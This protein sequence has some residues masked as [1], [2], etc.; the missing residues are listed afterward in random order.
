M[1]K[2]E[3]ITTFLITARFRRALPG[4]V[5]DAAAAVDTFADAA[6]EDAGSLLQILGEASEV[7][8]GQTNYLI[9]AEPAKGSTE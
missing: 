3:F 8:I 5:P 7:V 2:A 4:T 1:I 6:I 9:T